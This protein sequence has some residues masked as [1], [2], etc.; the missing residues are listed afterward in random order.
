MPRY[1]LTLEY[2]GGPYMG[3]QWQN[4]GPSVQGAVEEALGRLDPDGSEVYGSGRTDSGVHALAQVAH[5]D[6]VKDLR[7]DKVR[8]ALNHHLGDHPIS[9]LEAAVVPDD[10]H[11]RF[12]ATERR[13]LYRIIDRRPRLALDRGRVWRV[14]VRL[15]ADAMHAAAQTLIGR[16][17]FTTFRDTQCQAKD[18]VKTL[19]MARV[20]RIGAEIHCEF[21]ARSFLHKQVRSMVGSLVEV[22]WGKW[23]ARDMR[24]ALEA[25]DRQMCGPV[26]PPDGLYL[27]SVAYPAA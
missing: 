5:V 24:A 18:P 26:S 12:N 15:D 21:A 19:D 27:V 10:W 13:Y 9:V 1:K 7:A 6:L 4:H 2:D 3:W 11:A 14:P 8:D 25:R 20:A 16:H 17:D 23:N 22:G